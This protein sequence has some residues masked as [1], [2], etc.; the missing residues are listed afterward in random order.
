M[1][2]SRGTASSGARGQAQAQATVGGSDDAMGQLA[3][4]VDGLQA[5]ALAMND[6]IKNQSSLIDSTISSADRQ[7]AHL[8]K[9]NRR[10]R[11]LLGK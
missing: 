8:D 10:A 1:P 7:Q 4:L 5:Q 6:E 9:N 3:S 2:P 11:K